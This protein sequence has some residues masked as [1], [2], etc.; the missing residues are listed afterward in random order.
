MRAACAGPSA[1]APLLLL[2]WSA[3][4][5]CAAPLPGPGRRRRCLDRC[6]N[7]SWRA[8]APG[9]L[10]AVGWWRQRRGGAGGEGKGASATGRQQETER[11]GAAVEGARTCVEHSRGGAPRAA[12]PAPHA[13]VVRGAKAQAAAGDAAPAAAGWQGT[14]GSRQCLR[15]ARLCGQLLQHASTA[16]AHKQVLPARTHAPASVVRVTLA[17]AGWRAACVATIT[18]TPSAGRAGV[19]SRG[20]EGGRRAASAKRCCAQRRVMERSPSP[21]VATHT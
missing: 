17:A 9:R 2:C 16:P 21:P 8:W 4:A 6:K 7:Q 15:L 18:A 13:W 12:P 10:R 5:A 19:G 14:R 20:G 3:C 1:C 11:R